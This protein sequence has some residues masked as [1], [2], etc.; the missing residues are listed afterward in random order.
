L[1]LLAIAF[2]LLAACSGNGKPEEEAARER[3]LSLFGEEGLIEAEVV[4]RAYEQGRLGT[5]EEVEADM[6]PY[7]SPPDLDYQIPKPFD[8][9]GNFIPF[10]EM[11]DEQGAAFNLWSSRSAKVKEAAGAEKEAAVIAFRQ[12][13][14]GNDQ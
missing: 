14:E 3:E 13:S 2:T 6:A 10:S 5:R 1:A 8:K 4:I 12:A 7:F 9:G 11:N